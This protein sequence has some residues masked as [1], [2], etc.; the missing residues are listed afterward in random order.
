MTTTLSADA[1][2]DLGEAVRMATALLEN[3]LA[4]I[5]DADT[6]LVEN[7]AA[8]KFDPTM[9]LSADERARLALIHA[10]NAVR[11]AKNRIRV[12]LDVV[13]NGERVD[14]SPVAKDAAPVSV[15]PSYAATVGGRVLGP[16][17]EPVTRENG[18]YRVG[19]Y[20]SAWRRSVWAR[21]RPHHVFDAELPVETVEL[22]AGREGEDFYFIA[23]KGDPCFE[24]LT[25]IFNDAQLRTE[26]LDAVKVPRLS[27]SFPGERNRLAIMCELLVEKAANLRDRVRHDVDPNRAGEVAIRVRE[28]IILIHRA[29]FG[30]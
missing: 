27:L 11:E 8:V 2:G 5:A 21:I 30:E 10:I 3:A 19:R 15:A 26:T 22:R 1:V 20:D 4:R 25:D 14:A 18:W 6:E 23:V 16:H 12:V 13:L 29:L 28:Q 24:A 7:L 17:T 9:P